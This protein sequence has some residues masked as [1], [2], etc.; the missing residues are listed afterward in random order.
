MSPPFWFLISQEKQEKNGFQ[1]TITWFWTV[2]NKFN[3]QFKDFILDL[4]L[5]PNQ[6]TS[7][8]DYRIFTG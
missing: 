8:F 4:E 3:L 2:G 1:C 6:A 7:T 5:G